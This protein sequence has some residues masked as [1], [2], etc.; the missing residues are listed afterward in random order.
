M[1]SKGCFLLPMEETRNSR[2]RKK[3]HVMIHKIQIGFQTP[4]CPTTFLSRQK[5]EESS[6]K[7]KDGIFGLDLSLSLGYNKHYLLLYIFFL[8]KV[9]KSKNKSKNIFRIA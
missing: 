2:D 8:V 6:Q 1:M 7:H 5:N 3:N 4:I 9:N